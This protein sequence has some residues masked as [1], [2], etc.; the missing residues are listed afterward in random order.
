MIDLA[1]TIEPKSDQLNADDLIGRTLTIQITK[2]SKGNTGEQP[3]D[4]H[5]EGDNRKP[6]KPCKSMRRVMVQ[7]WGRDG[8]AYVGRSMTIYR[9]DSVKWGGAEVGGIRI[10]HMIYFGFKSLHG[11]EQITCLN[12][13][14]PLRRFLV[15]RPV[16]F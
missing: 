13:Q 1:T 15:L 4:I 11:A 7:V 9:D 12:K 14:S 16:I 2:V 6:Y 5:F 3:I 10:S 8:A